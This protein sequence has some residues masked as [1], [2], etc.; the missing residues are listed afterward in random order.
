MSVEIDPDL[1]QDPKPEGQEY[2]YYVFKQLPNVPSV[3]KVPPKDNTIINKVNTSP[4][5]SV[6][7]LKLK[8]T[9]EGMYQLQQRYPFYK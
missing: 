2:G 1:C 9:H 4:A 6:V 3:Q 7:D 8:I 5:G